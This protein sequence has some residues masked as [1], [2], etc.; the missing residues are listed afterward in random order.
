MTLGSEAVQ[1]GAVQ[2]A[3]ELDAFAPLLEALQP[4]TIMEIGVDRGGTTWFLSHF[5]PRIIAVDKHFWNPVPHVSSCSVE[6]IRGDTNDEAVFRRLK[7][8]MVDVLFIDGDHTF[9]GVAADFITY[10]QLLSTDGLVVFHD[11]AA[12]KDSGIGVPAFWE[13]IKRRYEGCVCE[14]LHEPTEWGGLGVF[15]AGLD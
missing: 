4:K 1:R 5:A 3:T 6:L 12:T 8:E 11:I 14:I 15:N 7:D 9:A 10:S 13:L 2:K